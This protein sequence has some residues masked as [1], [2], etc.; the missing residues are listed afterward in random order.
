MM[1]KDW[2]KRAREDACHYV[3]CFCREWT[4]ET[5]YRWGEIQTQLVID[6]FFE[7]QGVD[8]SDLIV[9][10]I[11][12]GAGRMTRALASRFKLVYAY[13][14]S[15]QYVKIAKEKNIHLKNVV[16]CVNDGVSFPEIDDESV[17]FVFSGWTMQ[18]MPTKEVVIKNIEEMSRVLKKDGLYK[19]D[20]AIRTHSRFKE[21]IISKIVTSKMVRFAAPLLGLDKL[22]LT[23]SWRGARFTEKEVVGILLRNGLTVNTLVEDDG[24]ERFYGKQVMKKWFYGRKKT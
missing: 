10:E 5:F 23:P 15:D 21:M 2:N 6:K 20:P 3:S 24:F 1:K 9:L 8:P 14:V 4:D 22:V 11:G 16:F 19:I 13:D 7:D 17:D 12:C 18:H